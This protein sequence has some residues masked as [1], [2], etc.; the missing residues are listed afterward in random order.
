MMQ[1]ASPM[2][3]MAPQTPVRAVW[4]FALQKQLRHGE[5]SF[6]LDMRCHSGA[7]RLVLFGPSGAGKTQ[8]LKMIAGLVRPDA[9]HIRLLGDTLYDAASSTVQTP[10]QRRLAY[11]FQDYALFPHLTVR[12]NIAFALRTGWRNPPPGLA[13]ATVDH[14]LGAFGLQALAAQYPHQLSGGQKQRTALARALVA[15]PRALLLDE[16]F[17]A[18][19]KQ[20]RVRLRAELAELQQRL[21]IPMLM[22]T[23]DEDDLRDLSDAV[24]HVEAGAVVSDPAAIPED[25]KENA[26]HAR[27]T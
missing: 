16:P 15:E 5:R 8:T 21:Q 26:P 4:D 24:L 9:G 2:G 17:A 11:V 23:H 13:H 6:Q 10:Q 18:L 12:Q 22:I 1:P 19:D 14:W 27:K 7:R 3:P 25:R 20:L